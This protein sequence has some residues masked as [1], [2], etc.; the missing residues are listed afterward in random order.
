MFVCKD[1]F[2]PLA[3]AGYN[4]Y[5]GVETVE[6]SLAVTNTSFHGGWFMLSGVALG[7]AAVQVKV[8]ASSVKGG[9]IEIWLDDLK[10]GRMIARVPIPS[11]GSSNNWITCTAAL[12]GVSGSHDV[13]V[14]FPAGREREIYVKRLQFIF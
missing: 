13:F 12:R 7:Q 8:L 6:K 4:N 9:E 1:G 2:S 11:T 10:T 14:K 3:A 5:Y